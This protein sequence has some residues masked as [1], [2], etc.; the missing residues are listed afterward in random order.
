MRINDPALR[1]SITVAI[2]N[3]DLRRIISATIFKAKSANELSAELRIPP[4]SI[5]RYIKQLSMLGIITGQSW[6][7]LDGGG[8]YVLYRSMVKSV[9]AMYE[10]GSLEVDLLP[11]EGILDRFMRFWTYMGR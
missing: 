5:Y 11:N 1:E 7:F 2:S 8:K 3:P 9:T 10:A 4:R 6:S